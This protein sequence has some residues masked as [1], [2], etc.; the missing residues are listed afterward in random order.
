[1][2]VVIWTLVIVKVIRRLVSQ[3]QMRSSSAPQSQPI[4]D[5]PKPK[6]IWRL[7]VAV[8]I[9]G[10]AITLG[11][12]AWIEYESGAVSVPNAEFHGSIKVGVPQLVKSVSAHLYLDQIQ[13]PDFPSA[14]LE[15][16]LIVGKPSPKCWPYIIDLSGDMRLSYAYF[17]P[18][19]IEMVRQDDGN[20]KQIVRGWVCGQ[21]SKV[22]T[23][24]ATGYMRR[25]IA[26]FRS[27]FVAL[28]TPFINRIVT[29]P[30]DLLRE[31]L[32]DFPRTFILYS[33]LD[34]PMPPDENIITLNNVPEEMKIEAA[35]PPTTGP[36]VSWEA[37]N[38]DL[39]ATAELVS[40]PGQLAANHALFWAGYSSRLCS[41]LSSMGWQYLT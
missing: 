33:R 6:Q 39:A 32:H 38:E 5:H 34:R 23:I 13:V 16:Q 28:R 31:D 36:G 26:D 1:M 18:G 29:Y 21:R 17:Q 11:V 20:P 7:V 41:I 25:N 24:S 30:Q 14:D 3:R 22:V 4:P 8:I 9:F 35:I 10:V 19:H 12:A 40:E 27:Y 37:R 15:I 2:R